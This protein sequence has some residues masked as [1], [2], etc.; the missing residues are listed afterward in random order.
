MI[1][2]TLP[3]PPSVNTYWRHPMSGRLA[4]RHL[5]SEKGRA[6]RSAVVSA[7]RGQLRAA[8]QLA[9]RLAV[10]IRAHAPDRRRRD[11]DNLPKGL[12]DSCTHAG[13]W[14]DDAQIDR[15][16]ILRCQPIAGGAVS[17]TVEAA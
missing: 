8:P 9:G 7:V 10:T 4:G 15:L 2:L 3:W 1:I 13:L 6:Y 17:M 12:L 11:L 14:G 5:I 16:T